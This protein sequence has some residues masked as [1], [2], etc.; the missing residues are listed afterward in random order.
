MGYAVPKSW[1]EVLRN[2]WWV[3]VVSLLVSLAVTPILRYLATR[4]KAGREHYLPGPRGGG[5]PSVGGMAICAG[6]LA[7]LAGSLAAMLYDPQQNAEIVA[8]FLS[9]PFNKPLANP[10]WNLI[11]IAAA[12][13]TITI[14]GLLGDTMKIG[15]KRQILG[16]I[17]SAAILLTCGVGIRMAR[18]VL[19]LLG[20]SQTTWV[21]PAA[22]TVM[23]VAFVMVMSGATK[24]LADLDGLCSGVTGIVALAFLVLATSLATWGYLPGTDE[25]R[26][27][28]CL[29]MA[30][31]VLGFLPYNAPPARAV[32]GGSGGMLLG[33]FV[34]VMMAMFS[35]EGHSRWLIASFVV[36]SVPLLD[37]GVAV[38][39]RI[40]TRRSIFANDRSHLHHQLL[41]RG[42][43]IKQVV[44]LFYAM[45]LLVGAT[46]ML[47]AVYVRLRYAV[48]AYLLLLGG[49]FIVMRAMG[50][51]TPK[52]QAGRAR[53]ATFSGP[54]NLV[55]TCV[56]RRVSLL[57]EFRRAA[58]DLD[59][60]LTIH[61]ADYSKLAPALKVADKTV[62]VPKVD[63]PDYV[64]HLIDYCRRHD[65]HGLIPLI[66]P[67]LLPLAQAKE[68]FA[69]IGTRLIVSWPEVVGICMDKGLTGEFL[70]KHG[71][72]TPHILTPEELQ[73]PE[74]PLF[75]KPRCGSASIEAHKVPDH[76]AL[77]YYIHN[78]SDIIV[79][80]FI[81]GTE[82]T[83]DVFAD[84]DG[85][86]RCAV[87]RERMAVLA[88]EVS[89]GRVVKN[90]RI[91]EES[92]R[93]VEALGGC[94]G[95]I[96]VQCF[97][98]PRD[99]IVFTEINPRFGGGVPLSIRAGADSPRWLLE[100]LMGRQP[101]VAMRGWTDGLIML[102]YDREIFVKPE[103]QLDG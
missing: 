70:L 93:L 64:P 66:D 57:Q 39:R 62:D 5:A 14:V 98:T 95:L 32:L 77:S 12:S 58:V 42:M 36:F 44:A 67:E 97:L 56:G 83:V 54:V 90:P 73:S 68:R 1:I 23:C 49:W 60:Q 33:L 103:E 79:Q 45:S 92:C 46:G 86:P 41:D 75:V 11:G 71:F 30:G 72:K 3:G 2:E 88:G 21:L 47:V 50:F 55:F 28:L 13:V 20:I 10:I 19:E 26:V 38:I 94:E 61:A 25:V 6:L 24:V 17:L 34:A 76:K 63:S 7:G 85:R 69:R 27:G 18:P 81:E 43:T 53:I 35:R 16:Q 51:T 59:T 99:E 80:E 102:R 8:T 84:F 74:F 37:A 91:M 82:Y 52:K 40:N 48:P 89:K 87:P 96:T 65:I 29:A 31:A 4:A 15:R 9:G 78:L 100:L 101:T 22:S